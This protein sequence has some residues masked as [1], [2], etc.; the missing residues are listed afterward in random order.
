MER[1]DD[2]NKKLFEVSQQHGESIVSLLTEIQHYQH[3]QKRALG[4]LKELECLCV[5]RTDRQ[6][7]YLSRKQLNAF[8]R[9]QRGYIAL[10]YTW[11]RSKYEDGTHGRYHVQARDRTDYEPS[12]VRNCIFHRITKY[13]HANGVK[14]LWIDRHSIIQDSERELGC[15]AP[16]C[17]HTS[18]NSNRNGMKVMDLVYSLSKHPVALLGR[19]INSRQE[20][21]LLAR[22]LQGELTF[23]SQS[24]SYILRGTNLREAYRALK[25]LSK[26][27]NDKWWTRG[28]TFQEN[29]RGG[30]NM[31][32]LIKHSSRLDWLKRSY[33]K[34]FGEVDGEL[35][36]LSVQFSEAATNFC[37]AFRAH[38]KNRHFTLSQEKVLQTCKEQIKLILGTA[39]RYTIPLES[40]SPMTP[41][42][43]YDIERRDMG[44]RWDRLDITA[45]CCQY[46]TRLNGRALKE[47]NFS[48][49]LSILTQC[50]VNGEVLHNGQ[51]NNPM[52]VSKMTVT[53]YLQTQFFRGIES[54]ATQCNLT[55][56]KGCR[57]IDVKLKESGIRTRG[58]L[59]ELGA[60]L[61]TSE[62]Q[63]GEIWVDTPQGVLELRQRK[64]LACLAE[65][66]LSHHC[67]T[68]HTA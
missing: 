59:W 48:L 50:L 44:K 67:E 23:R 9:Y 51:R 21:R 16:S 19:P 25:L 17:C 42:I 43:V 7:T 35:C 28:W 37:L 4:F 64:N 52:A 30:K 15:K 3:P 66:L 32:L 68:L 40:S 6:T 8:K 34:L 36:F 62:F 24:R 10:S 41:R 38:L 57:F 65:H 22:L 20:L 56:N 45:N 61:D 53:R 31:K 54:P 49:S 12:T 14:L 27:T 55:F 26:I 47:N 33:H 39:A 46:S 11:D 2:G 29:Y 18:C 5:E 1:E 58:H 13:M 63:P 60:I